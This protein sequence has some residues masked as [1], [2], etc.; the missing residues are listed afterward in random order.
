MHEETLPSVPSCGV[1]DPINI[2]ETC[3]TETETRDVPIWDTLVHVRIV[4][5]MLLYDE[6][7]QVS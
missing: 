1:S 5:D 6:D 7:Y 4:R 2:Y 3:H